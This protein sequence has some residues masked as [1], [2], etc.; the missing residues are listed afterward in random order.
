MIFETRRIPPSPG[1][2]GEGWGEGLPMCAPISNPLLLPQDIQ[3][4]SVSLRWDRGSQAFQLVT[5]ITG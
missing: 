4:R 1:T 3:S 2:P 5:F